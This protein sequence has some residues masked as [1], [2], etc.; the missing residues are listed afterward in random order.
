MKFLLWRFTS[1]A[2]C[3]CQRHQMSTI[4]CLDE[5]P[6]WFTSITVDMSF[7]QL[8]SH[9]WG[10]V[11]VPV[12]LFSKSWGSAENNTDIWIIF[13]ADRV[14]VRFETCQKTDSVK[15]TRRPRPFPATVNL[16]LNDPRY[17]HTFSY[18]LPFMAD[19]FLFFLSL[20]GFGFN[21]VGSARLRFFHSY[22]AHELGSCVTFSFKTHFYFSNLHFCRR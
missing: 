5:F 17:S 21:D 3:W 22:P 4:K 7:R 8:F 11:I 14:R 1:T 9:P 13:M 12:W 10:P 18:R 15:S 2:V 20:E 16:D 6:P 19:W